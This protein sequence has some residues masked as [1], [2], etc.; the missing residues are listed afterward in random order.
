M[1]ELSPSVKKN[2]RIILEK[3]PSL[4]LKEILSYW[5]QGE[6][7]EAEMYYRF[8][9][10]SKETTWIEELPELF[11]MLY[12]ESAEHAERL[13]R[14]Y[15]KIFPEEKPV[16]V[17]LP[18]LEVVLAFEDLRR[19]LKNGRLKEVLDILMENEKMTKEVYEYVFKVTEN[20]EVRDVALWLAGI[21]EQHYNRLKKLEEKYLSTMA[22]TQ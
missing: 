22:E 9:E 15:K 14:V 11:Y 12:Q 16:S 19:L 20:P 1:R 6:A 3:L 7:D 21:E 5:I 8:Y 10:L 17:D 18:N 4:S 2:M 13:F